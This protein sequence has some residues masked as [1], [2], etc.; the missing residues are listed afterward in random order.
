MKAPVQLGIQQ[1]D[2]LGLRRAPDIAQ[3]F[4]RD[5]CALHAGGVQERLQV[6]RQS[7]D[8]I[9]E[10]HV[11]FGGKASRIVVPVQQFVIR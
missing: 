9:G 10:Q 3:D 1:I 8:E 11:D 2:E 5:H 4:R 7:V 6:G